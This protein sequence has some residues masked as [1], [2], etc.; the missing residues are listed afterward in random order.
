MLKHFQPKQPHT[1]SSQ[2]QLPLFTF[3]INH[4]T[5]HFKPNPK[6]HHTPPALFKI[7]TQPPPLFSY[8]P[9]TQPHTYPNLITP[10]PLPK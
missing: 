3:P 9:P 2:L 1:P 8:F 4:L 10:F 7:L 6:H 5:P